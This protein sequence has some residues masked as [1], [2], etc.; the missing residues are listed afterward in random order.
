MQ[1]RCR[2]FALRLPASR[3]AEPLFFISIGLNIRLAIAESALCSIRMHMPVQRR[4]MHNMARRIRLIDMLLRHSI[5]LLLHFILRGPCSV[6]IP[7]MRRKLGPSSEAL[8]TRFG[9]FAVRGAVKYISRRIAREVLPVLPRRSVPLRRAVLCFSGGL[10]P[11]FTDIDTMAAISRKNQ[12]AN[13]IRITSV[14]YRK[15]VIPSLSR[16]AQPCCL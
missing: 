9:R 8:S 15:L 6:C 10:F 5:Y 12:N 7:Y 3:S 14:R 4:G 16:A 2:R 1:T 11:A 13:S